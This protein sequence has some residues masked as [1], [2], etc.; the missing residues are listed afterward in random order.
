ML[1]KLHE[2]LLA[3]TH[4]R[5]RVKVTDRHDKIT[6]LIADEI[7]G[8][9]AEYLDRETF[10]FK[11]VSIKKLASSSTINAVIIPKHIDYL[12]NNGSISFF[13]DI[14]AGL[15]INPIILEGDRILVEL[16]NR[17]ALKEITYEENREDYILNPEIFVPRN[18]KFPPISIPRSF[19]IYIY[20]SS[21]DIPKIMQDL[22]R[23]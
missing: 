17:R 18:L 9:K 20:I 12:F 11:E 21:F 10:K 2:A 3:A 15:N 16:F 1:R 7:I 19:G 4:L 22:P 5:L 6:D 23:I 14:Y 13:N 8:K